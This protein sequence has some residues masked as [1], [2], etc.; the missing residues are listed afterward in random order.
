MKYWS[1]WMKRA[2]NVL[3]KR[4]HR[5][6]QSP[7]NLNVLIMNMKGTALAIYSCYPPLFWDG[8]M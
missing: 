3:K 6:L 4:A 8:G 5:W 1:A 2:S 7:V